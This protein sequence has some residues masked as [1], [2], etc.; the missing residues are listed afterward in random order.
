MMQHFYID[1]GCKIQNNLSLVSYSP[2]NPIL[3][4]ETTAIQNA[5]TTT[6]NHITAGVNIYASDELIK[7]KNLE[8]TSTSRLNGAM[9]AQTV[10]LSSIA[11][12]DSS[13]L[14]C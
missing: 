12:N 4:I 1:Q 13:G 10:N 2:S 7:G 5:S 11:H 3:W 8:I 6:R 9:T 14:E